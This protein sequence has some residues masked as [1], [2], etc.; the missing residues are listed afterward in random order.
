MSGEFNPL[1]PL[2]IRISKIETTLAELAS[3]LEGRANKSCS[4]CGGHNE[5][6]RCDNEPSTWDYDEMAR[7]LAGKE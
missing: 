5:H 2:S 4:N 6:D 7:I 1:A 3:W